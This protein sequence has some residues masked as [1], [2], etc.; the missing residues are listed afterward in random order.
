MAAVV[1]AAAVL[2]VG[3]AAEAAR[4]PTPEQ[5]KRELADLQKEYDAITGDYNANRE[6]L[7][8]ARNAEEQ[9]GR[10]LADAERNY[11]DTRRQVMVIATLSYQGEPSAARI[12]FGD[13]EPH[14]SMHTTALLRQRA[15]ENNAA[16]TRLEKLRDQRLSAEESATEKR[17]DLQKRDKTLRTQRDRADDAIDR[18]RKKIEQLVLTPGG[19]RADGTWVPQLPDGRDYITPRTRLIRD[20]IK[21]RFALPAGIGCYR[22]LQD[23]GEHPLGRACDFMITT[24][25]TWPTPAEAAK[26]DRL[27]AWTIENARRLG[28][29]YVIYRQRIWQ[30]SGWRPMANRGGVTANHHDHVHISMY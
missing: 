5:L 15:V 27:A 21:E 4:K 19:R 24:G 22:S 1:A 16:I 7:E 13:A 11:E 14:E 2:M 3:S 28:V 6:A 29:K 8:D 10:R 18:I 23:G 17:Q 26:G 12:A 20:Q 30:G 25:G 9:A